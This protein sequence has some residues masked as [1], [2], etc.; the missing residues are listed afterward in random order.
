MS[1]PEEEPNELMQGWDMHY[2]LGT[3]HRAAGVQKRAQALVQ[4]C[5]QRQITFSSRHQ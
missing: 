5:D 4:L 1:S 3:Q 2:S